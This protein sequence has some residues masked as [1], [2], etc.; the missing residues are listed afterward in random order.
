MSSSSDLSAGSVII[1][2]RRV[3]SLWVWWC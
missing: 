3:S 1:V 2:L